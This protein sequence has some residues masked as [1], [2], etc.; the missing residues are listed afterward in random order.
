L[1]FTFP[2]MIPSIS[3]AARYTLDVLDDKSKAITIATWL[4]M[5]V[6]IVMFLLRE[7]I[8]YAML[9][10]FTIDDFLIFLAVVCM[11]LDKTHVEETNWHRYSELDSPSQYS[12]LYQTASVYL[13]P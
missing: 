10:K 6:F 8:R 11:A 9:R 13:V 7:T 3:L 2:I 12:Y 5:A 1:H 4:L